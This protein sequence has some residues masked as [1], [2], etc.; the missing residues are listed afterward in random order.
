MNLNRFPELETERLNMRE[1]TLQDLEFY[2]HHFNIK[3]IIDGCCFPGPKD[4]A[5]AHE[6]LLLYC[7]NPFKEDRGVRWGITLKGE[8]KLIGTCGIYDWKKT[9]RSAEI[10]YDL[11]PS[12][13]GQGLMI[14][15]LR[16]LLQYGFEVMLLNRV[17]AI[18]DSENARSMR[19]VRR[20]GFVQEGILRQRSYFNGQFRDDVIFSLLKDEWK[21]P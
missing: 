12:Y 21:R 9:L 4:L 5:T 1:M 17:Q 18:I 10:G 8:D 11:D 19:L 16:A 14:E 7:I 3:E 2:F 13:W 15:A 6:E 20:L